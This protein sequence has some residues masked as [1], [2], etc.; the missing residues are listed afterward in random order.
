MLLRAALLLL[1]VSVSNVTAQQS[2]LD[3]RFVTTSDVQV[4][5][6][7]AL[8]ARDMKAAGDDQTVRLDIYSNV[9]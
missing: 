2:L 4:E 3:G 7:L 6:N 8:D 9:R 1:L 5:L